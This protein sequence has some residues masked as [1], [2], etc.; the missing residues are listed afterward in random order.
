MEELIG[1]TLGQYQIEEKI[2]QGGMATVFR[3]RQQGL[4]RSVAV[5]ILPPNFAEERGFAQR[6]KREAQ[7]IAGLEHPNI[8]PVYDYGQQGQYSY[9]VMR[10]IEGSRTLGNVMR[11]SLSYNDIFHYLKQI[12]DALDYAHQHHIIHRDIKP[13]NILLADKWVFLADFGLAHLV[14]STTQLTQ[15]GTS[16][17]TPAYMSPEQSL[18]QKID[19]RTDVYAVGVMAYQMFTGQIPHHATTPQ[20]IIHRRN[21]EPP[22]SMRVINADI[23]MAVDQCV[24]T[25]LA[26]LPDNRFGSSGVFISALE[27]AI[28]QAN[29][30]NFKTTIQ[31]ISPQVGSKTPSSSSSAARARQ[32]CPNCRNN[33]PVGVTFCTIC[34]YSIPAVTQRPSSSPATLFSPSNP[35]TSAIIGGVVVLLLLLL[36]AGFLFIF[37]QMSATTVLPTPNVVAVIGVITTST[38]TAPATPAPTDTATT[39]P[40][41]T[42]IK[43]KSDSLVFDT[44]T[45]PPPTSTSIPTSTPTFV[46]TRVVQ[47]VFGSITKGQICNNKCIDQGSRVDI[48]FWSNF[49]TKASAIIYLNTGE[50]F[51][52]D[53]IEGWNLN[54]EKKC[55]NDAP[56]NLPLGKHKIQIISFNGPSFTINFCVDDC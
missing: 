28:N 56:L 43:K 33:I 13:G 14:E 18:G 5:K 7:A 10:Y 51:G 3:A 53:L 25:A 48:C 1:K 26:T 11:Q 22:P 50:Q 32:T 45:P 49:P 34:G 38:D 4:N 16:M 36:G 31:E 24:Q 19:A 44:A 42:P 21:T 15:T 30:N 37:N 39:E 54:S 47:K 17:G 8:L 35:M 2:G 20:A 46:P 40:T 12:A 6:F 41:V 52:A 27:Q 23:P 55:L 29:A 9:L